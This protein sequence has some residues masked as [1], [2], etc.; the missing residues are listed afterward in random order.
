M[1]QKPIKPIQGT[2]QIFKIS[3][4]RIETGESITNKSGKTYKLEE[5]LEL[6]KIN[7][8]KIIDSLPAQPGILILTGH[9][10]NGKRTLE[11]IKTNESIR[12]S[13][14]R[15]R[16]KNRFQSL[17]TYI[18]EDLFDHVQIQLAQAS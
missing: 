10:K 3:Q 2:E 12:A 16:N 9:Y 7:Y 18:K 8:Q 6:T 11:I 4:K 13:F 14:G 1:K 5:D 17:L 15:P